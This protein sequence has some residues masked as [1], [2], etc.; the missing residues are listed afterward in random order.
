M[1]RTATH[2]I[3]V[4]QLLLPRN[5]Q[6]QKP[7]TTPS[8][9]AGQD[10]ENASNDQSGQA[11]YNGEE[12][13]SYGPH[14]FIV[15]IR[16]QKTH[17]P[18][19]GI[20]VG[21]MGPKYG[22]APMDNGYMLFDNHRIPHFAF[23]SRYFQVDAESGTYKSKA[24]NPAVVYGSLTNVRVNIIMHARLVL[25][26]AVTV[27][28][29]YLTIRRQFRDRDSKDIKGPELTVLDY[30]TVQIRVMPL[31][32]TT[33]ALHYTGVEMGRQYAAT[34]SGIE[35]GDFSALADLHATS[36][37]LKSVC[38]SYAADGV[39]TVRR[40]LG[41]HGF[42]SGSGLIQLNND[43]LSKPTV[44]G[45]NWMITQQTASY[46][47]KKT[48]AIVEGKDDGPP[49]PG[50]QFSQCLR[51]YL[52]AKQ[53][54]VLVGNCTFDILGAFEV[55][56]SD[57][58]IVRAFERRVAHLAYLA[59]DAR[60]RQKRSWNSLLIQLHKLSN[61][62]SQLLLVRNFHSAIFNPSSPTSDLEAGS[63]IPAPAIPV[64][65]TNFRLFALHT[66]N[67][68]AVEFLTSNSI[69]AADIDALPD[70]ILR[71]MSE[72]RRHVVPLVDAWGIPDYLLD[73]ALGRYD[74][75]V[76]EDLFNRAHRLNPLNRETFN[77]YYW[78]EEIVMGEKDSAK[79]VLSKL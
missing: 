56:A 72:Q 22:Y 40:A 1:G 49:S 63:Q 9:H 5:S 26:R 8:N 24:Q 31:L 44:E 20:V 76:Y 38:T 34:R 11:P 33:F 57:I 66:I 32:A 42:H 58:D 28:M 19:N 69:S 71:V 79:E 15:Q 10:P 62:F 65:L 55:I 67:T 47:L 12:Y 54:K 36:S 78:D 61:A 77:P 48:T 74:G 60:I 2:A 41:G 59:Y 45:D 29:R 50:D 17:K 73:S 25:A 53:S 14:P 27:G 39:E 18:L 52:Q 23:L 4:A 43:Y 16:D 30:P 6:K 68:H 7:K 35:K 37:G 3:V 70:V 46:I 21:D 51:D 75:R 64:L 13:V